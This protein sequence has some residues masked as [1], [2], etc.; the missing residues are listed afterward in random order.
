MPLLNLSVQHGRT[1][2]DAHLTLETAV[3]RVTGQFSALV[4][5]TE[6]AADRQRVNLRVSCGRVANLVADEHVRDHGTLVPYRR[7]ILDDPS[8]SKN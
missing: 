6:W 8:T 3:Q 5:R 1:L 4:R 7:M 2:E